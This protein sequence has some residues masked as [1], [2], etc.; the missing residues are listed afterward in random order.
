M[1]IKKLPTTSNVVGS[2]EINKSDTFISTPLFIKKLPTT[3]N[4]VGSKEIN[5]SDTF[6]LKSFSALPL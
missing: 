3:S 6:I 5:K 4:V 1:G 2:K